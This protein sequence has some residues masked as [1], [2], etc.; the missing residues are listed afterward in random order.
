MK[1]IIIIFIMLISIGTVHAEEVMPDDNL[2]FLDRAIEK[3]QLWASFTPEKD[4]QLNLQF[5]NERLEEVRTMI[6]ENKPAQIQEAKIIHESHLAAIEESMEDMDVEDIRPIQTQLRE[7]EEGIIELMDETDDKDIEEIIS[8]MS[9]QTGLT[10]TEAK[11]EIEEKE[12]L[13]K[14]WITDEK[15]KELLDNVNSWDRVQTVIKDYEGETIIVRI[16][17]DRADT[18]V[19]NFKVQ[20]GSIIRCDCDSSNIIKINKDDIDNIV[21]AIDDRSQIR[22]VEMAIKNYGVTREQI[23]ESIG[24]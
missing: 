7:H 16:Q 11:N 15:L 9:T 6:R 21:A 12:W 14:G 20:S 13:D 17:E 3:I 23:R 2:Y 24:G 1:K 4:A 5:A 22:L 18:Q 8:E 10:S 19:F